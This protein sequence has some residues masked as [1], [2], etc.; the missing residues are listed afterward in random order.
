MR[1]QAIAYVLTSADQYCQHHCQQDI[2]SNLQ[3][4]SLAANNPTQLI[5]KQHT[6]LLLQNKHKLILQLMVSNTI[7]KMQV[8]EFF[9][10]SRFIGKIM[11]FYCF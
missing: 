9:L 11:V 4:S 10:T 1:K 8:V 2:K 3:G 6:R 5:L 7:L